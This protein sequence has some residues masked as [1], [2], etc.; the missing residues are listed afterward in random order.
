MARD[1]SFHELSYT[2]EAC[3]EHF[4]EAAWSL[5]CP[6]DF[7]AV[8]MWWG[9][10]IGGLLLGLL[11]FGGLYAAGTIYETGRDRR[12]AWRRGKP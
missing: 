5:H 1:W 12:R 11:F 2:Q 9:G 3:H 8:A 7:W 4:R 6:S 10:T